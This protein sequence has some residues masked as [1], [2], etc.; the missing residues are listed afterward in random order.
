MLQVSLA[1]FLL[2]TAAGAQSWGQLKSLASEA[3]AAKKY[4]EAADYWQ[5]ALA[6]CESAGGPRYIQSAAGLAQTYVEQDKQAE[7]EELYKKILAVLKPDSASDEGKDALRDYAAL[8]KKLNR[9]GEASELETKFALLA[10]KVEPPPSAEKQAYEQ[11]LAAKAAKEK[12]LADWQTLIKSAN[13]DQAQKHYPEAEQELKKALEIADK[14]GQ[15]Y[16][17]LGDTLNKLI[18]LYF[19]QDKFALAEPFYQRSVTVT[20]LGSGANSKE[21]ALALTGHGQVL[22][23]LNRRAEAIAEEGKADRIMASLSTPG[24]STG[25]TASGAYSSNSAAA[26]GTRSGTLLNRA[27]AARGINDATND[28]IN[29]SPD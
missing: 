8:M 18:Q 10:P 9:P 25:G 2:Q 21:Y 7:A 11:R 17:L 29:N 26:A 6:S 13:A 14:Q 12:E 19:A 24:G 23:K 16:K 5:K 27:K 15:N 1:L 22:R 4:T 20:R 3:E 28:A